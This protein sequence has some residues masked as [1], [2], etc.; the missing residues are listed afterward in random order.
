MAGQR[1]VPAGGA[2][3]IR[4]G[5]VRLEGGSA[6]A[7]PMLRMTAGLPF[8][9]AVFPCCQQ[10]QSKNRRFFVPENARTGLEIVAGFEPAISALCQNSA[11]P[12]VLHDRMWLRQVQ[13][14]S[15]DLPLK[16]SYSVVTEPRPKDGEVKAGIFL[17]C[18]VLCHAAQ[19]HC[20]ASSAR[21]WAA[22][23]WMT[24]RS[25]GFRMTLRTK[26]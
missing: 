12:Y 3:R 26:S 24:A 1:T 11:R 2:Y 16:R 23:A 15:L 21:I 13:I 17:G 7:A 5:V 4:T 18:R 20:A 14:R 6:T 19:R 25:S 22:R 8:R 9:R 10:K